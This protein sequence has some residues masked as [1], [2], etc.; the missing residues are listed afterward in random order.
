M[1]EHPKLDK[2]ADEIRQ[3]YTSDRLQAEAL[4][5]QFLKNTLG[6]ISPEDRLEI[7]DKLTKKFNLDGTFPLEQ[8]NLDQEV[9]GRI[10]SFLLGRAVSQ[11]ELS[12]EELL[13][14][15]AD[16]LKTIFDMLNQL[17]SVINTAFLGQRQGP[18]TIRQM[19]GFHLEGGDQTRSLKDYLGQINRAFLTAQEAFKYAAEKK[20]KEILVE[21]APD[22][23]AASARGG[24]KIGR[25]R[26]AEHF[27][28]YAEKFKAFKK[29]VDSGRYTEE[30]LR[31]FENSCQKIFLQKGD[32]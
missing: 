16:S 5:E 21:L 24:L 18:E 1:A 10:F 29:W 7:I 2:L 23:I 27:E 28:L 20:M 15:L 25:L 3:I 13:Q 30:L 32:A 31:E 12:S 22:R 9:V 14:R 6:E 8:L 19:I 17:V 11:A 4:V 26:K